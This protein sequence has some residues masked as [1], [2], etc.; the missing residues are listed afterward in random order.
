MSYGNQAVFGLCFQNSGGAVLTNS[1]HYIPFVSEDIKVEKPDI[2]KQGNRGIL[3][4]GDSY[5]GMNTVGGSIV[6]EAHP[7]SMGVLFKSMFGDP[8]TSLVNSHYQHIFKPRT[9]DWDDKYANQPAT[10]LMDRDVSS[11]FVYYDMIGTSIELNAKNGEFL[12]A[13]VQFVGANYSN[14]ATVSASFPSDSTWTWDAASI[15]DG[16][17]ATDRIVDLT[18][19]VDEKLEAKHTMNATKLPSRIKR[20]DRRSIEISGTMKFESMADYDNFLNKTERNVTA[21][22]RNNVEISSGYY[23]TLEIIAPLGRTTEFGMPVGGPGE[24]EAT[25]AMSAKYSVT[26]ATATQFTLTNTQTAY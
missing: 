20:T 21:T 1:V 7:I 3:D 14:S 18:V 9:N 6:C 24:V 12:T 5:E 22:F 23:E 8:A 13:N 4:E 19:K 2:M 17:T 11:N 15:S 26:S 16:G 10:V 25:F